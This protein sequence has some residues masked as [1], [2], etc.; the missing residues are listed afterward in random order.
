MPAYPP[1]T[2]I[3]LPVQT[4]VS[5]GWGALMLLVALQLSIKGL[6]LPPIPPQTIIS[7]PVHTALEAPGGGPVAGLVSVQLSVTGLYLPP[8]LSDMGVLPEIVIPPHRIIS[9]PVQTIAGEERRKGALIVVVTRQLSVT[10]SYLPPVAKGKLPAPPPHTIISVPV[11]IALW[12]ARPTGAL[13]V[14]VAVQVSVA[15]SYLAP[16]FNQ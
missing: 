5:R 13:V 9:L 14:L 15:G 2:I 12:P 1:H 4:G 6:Y 8:S 7:V 10:G 11:Q 3:L 16:V